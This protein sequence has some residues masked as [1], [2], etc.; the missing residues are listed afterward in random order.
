LREK[1]TLR[2]LG[3]WTHYGGDAS[4]PLHVSVHYNGW[5]DY[6]NRNGYTTKKIHAHFEGELVKHNL[7]GAAVAAEV[8]PCWPCGCSIG[9]RTKALLLASL[10]Q[11]GPLYALEKEGGFKRGDLR[12]LAFA[13]TRLAAGAT[14][15][16]D[17]IVQAWEE[18]AET[19]VGYPMVNV[20]DIESGTVRATGELFGAD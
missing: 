4:Q 18:S 8:G 9:D 17:M 2:D 15:V 16:R 7:Q 6:P 20:K 13:T 19:P 3:V 11:V 1:L 14:A 10:A 5:G 12:G